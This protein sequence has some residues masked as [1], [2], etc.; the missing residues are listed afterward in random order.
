MENLLYECH[1]T[2]EPIIDNDTLLEILNIACY[3][4]KF[5]IADLF[6]QKRKED[7]PERSKYDTFL[8]GHSNN[9]SEL[10]DRMLNLIYFCQKANIKVWRY[11]IEG[12][13]LDSRIDDKFNLI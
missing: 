13:I 7:T 10:T 12:I 8:T 11:K 3:H 4:F 6:M 5:K 2:L 1:I 9:Y